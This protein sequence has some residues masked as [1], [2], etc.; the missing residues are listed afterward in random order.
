[1]TR[2][3]GGGINPN[4]PFVCSTSTPGFRKLL[5]KAFTLSDSPLSVKHYRCYNKNSN[6]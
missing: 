3:K 6:Y 4:T 5:Q 2:F 1:M